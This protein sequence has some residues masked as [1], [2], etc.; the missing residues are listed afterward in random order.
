MYKGDNRDFSKEWYIQHAGNVKSY[1]NN[2]AYYAMQLAWDSS[3]D[4]DR[5]VKMKQL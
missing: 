4:N 5:S 2:V 1:V 3:V